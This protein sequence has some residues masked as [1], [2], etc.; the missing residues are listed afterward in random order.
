ML[1][2]VLGRRIAAVIVRER[3]LRWPVPRDIGATIRGQ[4]IVSVQ[5]RAKYLLFRTEGGTLLVHLGM[6]GSLRV[7]EGETRPGSHD[8]VDVVLE[9][10]SRLRYCD[11]RRFGCILWTG[12]PPEDHPLLRRLGPEP[13]D[14]EFNGS[15]LFRLSRGRRTAV[16]SF[17]MD[18]RV[19]AGVGNIYANE[20]LFRAG[21]APNR[22]AGRI[23]ERRY[24]TLRETIAAVLDQALRE[25]G[26]TLRD[27]VS[28]DGRPGYF[29][30]SL[31]V[32]GRGGEPCPRC[33]TP[34]RALRIGQRASYHCPSCQR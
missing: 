28:S 3:R 30:Q 10:G 25:G 9:D 33:A 31:A 2:H 16:K 6:S 19:V 24:E 14:A 20:A 26:T 21:I 18:A 17:I 1:P 27:F 7:L 13:F 5:R 23:S 29:A 22:R 32:Y 4:R 8:H 34:L 12:E 11:P 15:Y